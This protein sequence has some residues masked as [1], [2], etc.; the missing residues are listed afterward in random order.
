[1]ILAQATDFLEALKPYGLLGVVLAFF[2]GWAIWTG[3][4]DVERE[5]ARDLREEK[6]EESLMAVVK[7]MNHLTH[8]I[9]MDVSTRPQIAQRTRDEAA[10]LAR[11]VSPDENR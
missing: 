3:R 10:E 9:S 11:T 1:M 7:A 4:R 2:M 5:K 8:G 6:R